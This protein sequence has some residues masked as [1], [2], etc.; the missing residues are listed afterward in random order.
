M[1]R[2]LLLSLVLIFAL[3]LGS[4]TFAQ[5]ESKLEGHWARNEIDKTF[6]AY[7]FPYMA[8]NSFEGFEPNTGT[9]KQDFTL[10]LISLFRDRGYEVSGLGDPGILT[11]RD[12]ASIIGSRLVET[13]FAIDGSHQLPFTDISSMSEAEKGYLSLLHQLGIVKGESNSV[14]NPIRRLS[15]A[16]AVVLVQRLDGVLKK[17]NEISFQVTNNE[18][19]YDKQEEMATMIGE[20]KVTLIITKEFP[21]P[22]YSLEIEKIVRENELFR[23]H[24]RIDQ[25]DP[26]MIYPQ[27]I[28]YQ[29]LT[30]E[31]PKVEL[32]EPPYNFVVEGFR[33][34]D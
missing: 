10:S 34:T 30:V 27:V 23:I 18:Q 24:F 6:M 21:T 5:L 9:T 7:Y 1:R 33:I 25:P 4:M 17:Q 11:R 28:T 12:M 31:I 19:S 26:D 29:T 15:Q 22:G 16:E 14:F 3:S 20:D 2:K 32:G 13:G 8:K